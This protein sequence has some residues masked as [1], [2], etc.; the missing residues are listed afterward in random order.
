MMV[1]HVSE[2]EYLVLVTVGN[3]DQNW[4]KGQNGQN[5]TL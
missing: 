4:Q 3:Q 5:R 1:S 2:V